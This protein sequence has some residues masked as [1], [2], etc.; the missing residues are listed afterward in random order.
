VTNEQDDD[1]EKKGACAGTRSHRDATDAPSHAAH[2]LDD[3]R[4]GKQQH[5]PSVSS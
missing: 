3:Q 1:R 4:R 5:K 2:G